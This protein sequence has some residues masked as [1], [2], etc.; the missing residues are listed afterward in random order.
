LLSDGALQCDTERVERLQGCCAE[1]AR[2]CAV[3]ACLCPGEAYRPVLSI[4]LAA[5]TASV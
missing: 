4:L 2:C 1:C 5:V 3:S